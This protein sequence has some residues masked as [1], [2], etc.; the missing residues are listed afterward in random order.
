MKRIISVLLAIAIMLSITGNVFA[1]REKYIDIIIKIPTQGNL[2]S[3]VTEVWDVEG[4][5][6][7]GNCYI[8]GNGDGT[9]DVTVTIVPTGDVRFE[10]VEEIM[11]VVRING[12]IP[13]SAKLNEDGGAEVAGLVY[14]YS[15]THAML[16]YRLGLVQGIGTDDSGRP[17]FDLAS[18]ANRVEGITMLIRLLGKEDEAKAYPETHKFDDVPKW[19]DGYVS[20]AYDNGLVNGVSETMFDSYSELGTDM[21]LTF[22]LRALGYSDKNGDFEW[23]N[24]YELA[25]EC[26]ITEF[27]YD[28]YEAYYGG[29]LRA[30]MF[31]LSYMSLFS[32]VKDTEVTLA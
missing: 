7:R 1:I 30:Y 11:D 6:E 23:N 25:T 8:R 5:F 3:A 4:N 15:G 13:N 9:Y 28:V 24:P 21:Y 22:V 32:K 2:R 17:V 26:G 10:T 16:L 27:E 12:E 14:N 29:F 20:Y 19:A 18:R 31:D